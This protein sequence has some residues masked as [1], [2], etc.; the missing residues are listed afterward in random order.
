MSKFLDGALADSKV[1]VV[2]LTDSQG[3][4]HSIRMLLNAKDTSSDVVATEA[5]KEYS[6]SSDE[7]ESPTIIIDGGGLRRILDRVCLEGSA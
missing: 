1:I 2:E 3:S 5:G 4:N 6:L 7:F